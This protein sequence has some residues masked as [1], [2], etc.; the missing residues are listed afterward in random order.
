MIA[1]QFINY[2]NQTS[3]EHIK[4]YAKHRA[5]LCFDLEDS[6]KISEKQ[7][8]RNCFKKI[9]AEIV[10]EIPLTKIALRMN[11]DA[12]EFNKDMEAI[13]NS[14][15]NSILLPKIETVNQIKRIENLFKDKN[16]RFDEMVPI[17]ETK[18]AMTNLEKI[19]DLLPPKITR[20][21][22]GHCDY[23]L[24]IKAF[25]F[26][27]QNS[28]EYW[29]WIKKIHSAV[30]NKNL[31]IINSPYLELDNYSFF[32][33]MLHNL[34]D[35]FGPEA[36]QTALNSMQS[37]LINKFKPESEHIN[38]NELIRHRLDLRVPYKYENKII[39]SYE[40]NNKDKM[41][42]ISEKSKILI[43]PHEY[44]AA[45]KYSSAKKLRSINFTFVGGCFPVQY[46]ILFEDLF[47]QKLKRRIESEYKIEFNINIIRY[48]QFNT[49]LK[50]IKKYN[51]TFPADILVFH[52]RP[53]P[54][55]RLVKIFYRYLNQN[56]KVINSINIPLLPISNPEKYDISKYEKTVIKNTYKEETRFHKLLIDLNYLIGRCFGNM[57]YALKKYYE[58]MLDIVK[59]SK[60]TNIK[61]LILG[62]GYRNNTLLSKI[63]CEK[64]NKY[65]QDKFTGKDIPY[66]E[67]LSCLSVNTN[68]YFQ[69]NGIHASEKY[70]ELIAEILFKELKYLISEQNSSVQY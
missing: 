61:L 13:S 39:E 4:K 8:Y 65:L 53:E 11:S 70:H 28:I 51:D 15:I 7:Y 46:D 32:R 22:F 36:G 66:M 27:H 34:Y 17:I 19:V 49:C 21:G 18:T 44:L 64:L 62:I 20:L 68:Q 52:V 59:Y 69:S 37:E 16:I 63:L 31:T 3:L 54:F 56:G 55:L 6:I 25:P 42:S 50:K 48:E 45:K 67:N 14:F 2:N 12:P 60:Q 41:F 5:V 23:N 10:P 29:K 1:Y 30:S 58:V 43:S 24:D 33:S 26:F 47:H 38:F 35:M 9:T 40:S 57:N